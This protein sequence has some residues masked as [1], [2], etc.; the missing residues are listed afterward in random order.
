MNRFV[1]ASVVVN[2]E[3]EIVHL[4][5]KT[6][7][8]L[9]PAAGHPTFSLSKMAREGLLVDLR[10]ALSKAK[11]ENII[12][13]KEGV[14]VQSNGHTR[15][16][17]LEI[18]PLQGGPGEHY[19]VIVFQDVPSAA[20]RSR[21]EK[22]SA[23]NARHGVSRENAQVKQ[24]L[25]RLREQ[26]QSLI[27]EHETTTEEFKSANEEVLSANEELQSTNEELETAKEELQSSNEELT[28]LNEEL[29]NRNVELTA[30]NNDL[31]TCWAM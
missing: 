9:E 3:M 12:V 15:E 10:A 4:R 31:L 24:E 25:G 19:Y 13:R 30:V 5:G 21:Q 2:D 23:A 26:F 11:K 16:V 14:H 17:N 22:K 18:T 7:A 1:P 28:T 6:G 20:A 8:Y 29:Q 27:E